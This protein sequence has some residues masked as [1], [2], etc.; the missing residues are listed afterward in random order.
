M[1]VEFQLLDDILNAANFILK[2][3]ES[4]SLSELEENELVAYSVL[5]QFSVIGEALNRLDRANPA[6]ANTIENIHDIIGFRNRIVHG[7]NAVDYEILHEIIQ[8]HL[9][10]LISQVQAIQDSL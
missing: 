9:Q 10:P 4:L 8:S 5:Y 1:R 3:A 6:I 7:Y 2:N